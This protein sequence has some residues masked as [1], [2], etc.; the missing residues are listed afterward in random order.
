M[1]LEALAFVKA[2]WVKPL[3]KQ[4][5]RISGER[6]KEYDRLRD[7]FVDPN[8]LKDVYVAPQLQDR[9]PRRLL[10]DCFL[11]FRMIFRRWLNRSASS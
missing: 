10:P 9:N 11:S 7:E 4:L 3:W 8:V 6:A 1:V 2:E 5:E